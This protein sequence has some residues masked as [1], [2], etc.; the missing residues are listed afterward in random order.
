MKHVT[1]AALLPLLAC[2]ALAQPQG[3]VGLY[4][5]VTVTGSIL[6]PSP[7]AVAEDAAQAARLTVRRASR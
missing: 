4:S 2:P 3:K 6:E 7:V 5:D 1:A